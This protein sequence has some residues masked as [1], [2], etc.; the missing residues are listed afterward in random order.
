VYRDIQACHIS[1]TLVHKEPRQSFARF[2]CDSY[3]GLF[4]SP[5]HSAVSVIK[6][7]MYIRRSGGRF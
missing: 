6:L 7:F 1:V 4:I 3:T 2:F 5:R